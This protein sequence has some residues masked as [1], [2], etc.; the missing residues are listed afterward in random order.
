MDLEPGRQQHHQQQS[1]R[2]LL[3]LGS[4][5]GPGQ[6]DMFFSWPQA[7]EAPSHGEPWITRLSTEH[8]AAQSLVD[9]VVR[10]I[11]PEIYL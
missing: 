7:S 6:S 8:V 9:A 3:R 1:Q 5:T 4:Q 2:R 11:D 10:H